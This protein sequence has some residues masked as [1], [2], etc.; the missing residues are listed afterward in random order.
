MFLAAGCGS[1]TPSGSTSTTT[2]SAPTSSAP[3]VPNPLSLAKLTSNPCAALTAAQLE[4]YIGAIRVSLPSAADGST[5]PS[6]LYDPVDG[7]QG[8]VSVTALPNFGGPANLGQPGLEWSQKIGD[9]AGYPA[10]NA[11]AAGPKGPQAGDCATVVVISD[12]AAVHIYV[13]AA[14]PDYKYYTNACAPAN[15]LAP[16]VIA[17]LKSGG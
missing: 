14:E 1:S 12:Q 4:P 13:Q 5:G 3:A 8:S 7:N 2:T 10:E 9:V 16:D 11:S 17:F 15:A 6:C